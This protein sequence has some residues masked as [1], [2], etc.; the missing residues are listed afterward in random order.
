MGFF[1]FL[2]HSNLFLDH[3]LNLEC[4]IFFVRHFSFILLIFHFLNFFLIFFLHI[5]V[6]SP[7]FLV[8]ILIP[9]GEVLAS[10]QSIYSQNIFLY[11]NVSCRECFCV[12]VL[13]AVYSC[14][15]ACGCVCVCVCVCAHVFLCVCI[16]SCL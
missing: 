8:L 2:N 6:S 5:L 4:S 13:K 14:F 11:L 1:T 16:K 15:S 9:G 3:L 10:P 12:Y 7:F